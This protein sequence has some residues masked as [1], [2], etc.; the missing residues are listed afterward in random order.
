MF[1][2]K[3]EITVSTPEPVL[4][5][6]EDWYVLGRRLG[7]PDANLDKFAQDCEG[8]TLQRSFPVTVN[9]ILDNAVAH[10]SDN[11]SLWFY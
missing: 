1:N 11:V 8:E 3:G 9:K 10:G 4:G 7:V 2:R 6:Q 5:I